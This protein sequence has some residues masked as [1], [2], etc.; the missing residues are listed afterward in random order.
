MSGRLERKRHIALITLLALVFSIAIGSM[1]AQAQSNGKLDGEETQELSPQLV[2]PNRAPEPWPEMVARRKAEFAANPKAPQFARPL[3][4]EK[5]IMA[6]PQF[7]AANEADPVEGVLVEWWHACTPVPN[8]FDRMW[9]AIIGAAVRSGATAYVYLFPYFGHSPEVTLASASAMLEA[10]EGVSADDVYWIQDFA[11]DAF[12]IRDFGPLFVRDIYTQDLSIEDPL[13][14][15]GLIYDDDQP[16]E[17]ASRIGVPISDFNLYFEGGNFLPNGGG[18]AI[19]SSVVLDANPHYTEAEIREIFFQQLGCEELIIVQALDDWATGH[20]DM[21]LA[22]A[23]HT[24]LLVGEYTRLQDRVNRAII[25]DNVANKLT[26]L[27]DPETGEEIQIVRMPMPSSCPPRLPWLPELK[28]PRPYEPPAAPSCPGLPSRFRSWRTYLNVGLING[29]VLM[30]VYAQDRTYEA[31]A[32]QIWEDLGFEVTPVKADAITPAAGQIHCIMKTLDS[33][34]QE[35]D[36]IVADSL[37][38]PAKPSEFALQQSFPNPFNPD[39]WIPYKLAED[40]NV[41]ITIY[42]AA[43]KEV[44]TLDIGRKPAGSY[45]TKSK[46]AHWDGRNEAGESV[47]SGVYFYTIQAGEFTATRK[48]ILAK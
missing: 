23:N 3:T 31:E 9:M 25:E 46:A 38:A 28:K 7:I 13:Y 22:W 19:V 12:W 45:T 26:G 30:P 34:T 24:T 21:W 40:V 18:L 11:T 8:E 32:I 20:V 44:R 1:I 16:K 6:V 17:F 2:F 47:S 41:T 37:A 43:G 29:T 36:S 39:T 27:V 42:D 10:V 15:P 4:V 5:R 48:M 35:S 14:Y 33:S